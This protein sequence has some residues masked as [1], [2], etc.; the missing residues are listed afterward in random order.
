MSRPRWLGLLVI[1]AFFLA[2]PLPAETPT[3]SFAQTST[4]YGKQVVPQEQHRSH[5]LDNLPGFGDPEQALRDR[6]LQVAN[7]RDRQSLVEQLFKHRELLEEFQK[8]FKEK[9]KRD[10]SP[11]D[12]EVL[13]NLLGD[14]N[15]IDNPAFR[16]LIDD[17]DLRKQL[18]QMV[19][20][21][22]EMPPELMKD[23]QNLA[24][25]LAKWQGGSAP[26]KGPIKGQPNTGNT[27]DRPSPNP[28]DN[29]L[30]TTQPVSANSPSP[31]GLPDGLTRMLNNLAD[32]LKNLDYADDSGALRD[33]INQL[34]RV[35]FGDSALKLDQLDPGQVDSLVRMAKMLTPE[36]IRSLDLPSLRGSGWM[37]RM[38]S[39]P[40]GVRMPSF[41]MPN[42]RMPSTPSLPDGGPSLGLIWLLVLA[43][44]AVLAWKSGSWL[45]AARADDADPAWQL[46]GWPVAPSR[47][48]TRGDLIRAFEYLAL[49]LLGPAARTCHHHD[50][51]Q[52][53]G[54]VGEAE[55]PQRGE[56]AKQLAEL[57]EQARYA[58]EQACDDLPLSQRDQDVARQ[59][60]CLLAGV[61]VA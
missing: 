9:N 32:D 14:P 45:R 26:L 48:A 25:G 27:L 13:K 10:P 21:N 24:K 47:V 55:L 33:A 6:L 39:M 31:S 42:F 53:L 50:L 3:S 15:L 8:Q 18:Q 11:A 2:A 38:P 44:L 17:P 7:L 61:T 58:P 52:R 56:A 36:N 41:Q 20:G 49:R 60:L 51:A 46:G 4:G 43:L 30:T 57:Y 5:S 54:R 12:L 40:A 35:G 23:F 28:V 19:H 1:G 37:P 16:K 59:A 29:P 22:K 34:G